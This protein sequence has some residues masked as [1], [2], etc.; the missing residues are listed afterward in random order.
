[1]KERILFVAL[2]AW[3]LISL[4]IPLSSR[5]AAQAGATS[6]PA[7]EV[8]SIRLNKTVGG[9]ARRK[10]TP[11]NFAYT[12]VL[13]AE[14]IKLAFG[15]NNRQLLGPRRIYEDRYD[16][17][18]KAS[19]PAREDE[20][21]VMLRTLMTDRFQMKFHR[22]N[23][24]APVYALL[25]EK[26][27]PTFTASRSDNLPER[28]VSKDSIVFVKASMADLAATL[29]SFADRIVVDQTGL[30]GFY[31]FKLSFSGVAGNSEASIYGA[32]EASMLSALQSLGL[33]MEPRTATVEFVVVDEI[34]GVRTAN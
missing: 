22:E 2:V 4:L 16:I 11:G 1:M 21:L 19:T 13:L 31:D 12:N 26:D 10:I 25:V 7:F 20:I 23:R 33:K 24:E 14:Y 30:S 15:I 18:G 34:A 27:G 5:G 9:E 6:S 8:V 3:M 17:V 28:V 29:H 32:V